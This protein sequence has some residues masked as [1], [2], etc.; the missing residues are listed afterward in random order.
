MS[1]LGIAVVLVSWQTVRVIRRDRRLQE[2]NAAMSLT[3]EYLVVRKF[4]EWTY[5]TSGNLSRY[6]T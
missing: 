2:A 5:C 6:Q 1:A 4:H 3:V